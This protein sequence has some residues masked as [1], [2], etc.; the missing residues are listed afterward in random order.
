MPG[1]KSA[2]GAS[3]K[4]SSDSGEGLVCKKNIAGRAIDRGRGAAPYLG[5]VASLGVLGLLF[6]LG[7]EVLP[8]RLLLLKLLLCDGGGGGWSR[9]PTDRGYRMRVEPMPRG[10][11]GPL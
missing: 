3:G 10:P 6:G 7:L 5:G 11:G 4:D 1:I 2:I 9:S 8:L